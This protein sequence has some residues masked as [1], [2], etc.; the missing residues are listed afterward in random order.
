MKA[1]SAAGTAQTR[2][3]FTVAAELALPEHA[4]RIVGDSKEVGSAAMY[5]SQVE[6]RE[7]TFTYKS[8]M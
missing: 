1:G 6:G 4:V 5:I 3:N 7:L 2:A 8:L